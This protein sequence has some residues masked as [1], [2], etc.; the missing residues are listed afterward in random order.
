M[1]DRVID[2]KVIDLSHSLDPTTPVYAGYPPVEIRVL[3][4]TRYS[5]PGGRRALNSSRIS[6]GVHCGTHM[7]APFHFFE[8][9]ATIDR[10]DLRHCVGEAHLVHVDVPAD[11]RIERSHLT[12]HAEQIARC[13]KIVLS[14]GW[15]KQWGRPE[16]FTQHPVMTPD[17]A[18]FLIECGVHLVGVDFPSVDRAPFLTHVALLG[19]NVLIL[20]NLTNLSEIRADSFRLVAVPL[21]FTGRDGSPVRAIALQTA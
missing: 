15:A 10:V 5:I 18:D 2:P 13:G 4:S 7:D 12:S 16:Y 3:E 8:D 6:I 17:A 20:E 9:G 1:A 14:T 11:G 21:K 19:H